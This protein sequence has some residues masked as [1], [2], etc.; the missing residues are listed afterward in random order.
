MAEESRYVS[1]AEVKELLNKEAEERE[2]SYE[3][4]LAL[5]HAEK[6]VKMDKEET[7]ELVEKLQ[8]EFN[9]MKEKLA[10][11]TADILPTDIDGV[12]AVFSKDRYTPSQDEA[13]GIINL[14]KQYVEG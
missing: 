5:S 4:S 14:V 1:L 9:F 11:K 6:F 12:L 10:Y 3:Q 8:D 2:L 7:K 13:E